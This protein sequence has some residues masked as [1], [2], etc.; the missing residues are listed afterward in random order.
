MKFYNEDDMTEEKFNKYWDMIDEQCEA[1]IKK[2][3]L[4]NEG[5]ILQFNNEEDL[6]NYYRSKGAVTFE[7]WENNMREKYNI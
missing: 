3:K 4:L 5:S 1:T 7:E 2:A 6:L